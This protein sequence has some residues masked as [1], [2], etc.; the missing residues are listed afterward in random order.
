MLGLLYN[1]FASRDPY[2]P[3][4]NCCCSAI[5][6][7]DDVFPLSVCTLYNQFVL[8]MIYRKII[9]FFKLK[10]FQNLNKKKQKF[11]IPA[12]LVPIMQTS[13]GLSCAADK[14]PRGAPGSREVPTNTVERA[15][16]V[17]KEQRVKAKEPRT[18]RALVPLFLS[19]ACAQL[20]FEHGPNHNKNNSSRTQQ[21]GVQRAHLEETRWKTLKS[22]RGRHYSRRRRTKK[23]S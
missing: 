2:K 22:I 18:E 21:Y 7:I 19:L 13:R 5:A 8:R 12:R 14:W 4:W 20:S 23:K 1:M 16:Q 3:I 10:I 11:T 15:K 9:V 17:C 6:E